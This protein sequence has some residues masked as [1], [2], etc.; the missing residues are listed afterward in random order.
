MI[1]TGKVQV[2]LVAVPALG[3]SGN[4]YCQSSSDAELA[5]QPATRVA[6]LISVPFQSN[7]DFG[8]RFDDGGFNGT[9]QFP[10]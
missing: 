8:G 7:I 5:R 3:W 1:H 10:R 9:P 6:S 4:T 2:L